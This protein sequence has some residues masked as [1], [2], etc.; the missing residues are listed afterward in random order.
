MITI[1]TIVN[2]PTK[3][4]KKS[5]MRKIIFFTLFFQLCGYSQTIA[6]TGLGQDDSKILEY[7]IVMG[8]SYRM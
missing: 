7:F 3:Q 5:N 6:T 8:C 2:K 1:I 4:K